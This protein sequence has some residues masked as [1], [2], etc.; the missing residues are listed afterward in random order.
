MIEFI[1]T[2]AVAVIVLAVAWWLIQQVGFP[3]EAMKF[4]T[5][6]FVALVAVVVIYFLLS[7]SGGHGIPRLR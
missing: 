1:I 4:I 5:I 7:L 3:P 2:L 6:A